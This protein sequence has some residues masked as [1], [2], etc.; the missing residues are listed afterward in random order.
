MVVGEDAGRPKTKTQNKDAS[1]QDRKFA[2]NI[3]LKM[4]FRTP[5]EI[6]QHQSF[7]SV[8]PELVTFHSV[9][10]VMCHRSD[11]TFA[12]SVLSSLY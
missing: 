3:D 6:F 11:S 5:A 7:V 12:S 2:L 10:W 1:A 4:A 8:C 9:M